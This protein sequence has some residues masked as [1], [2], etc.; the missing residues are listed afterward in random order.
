MCKCPKCGST[1]IDLYY[2]YHNH[3]IWYDCNN[4]GNEWDDF[5]PM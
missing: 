2:P 1:D 4:C 5:E 3:I